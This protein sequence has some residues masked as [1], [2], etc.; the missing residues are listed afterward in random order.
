MM[1]AWSRIITA[2]MVK[3][4]ISFGIICS[5]FPEFVGKLDLGSEEK[6]KLEEV[7]GLDFNVW[8]M[9]VP[10]T[11]KGKIT[12]RTIF[13]GIGFDLMIDLPLRQSYGNV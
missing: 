2:M 7:L 8:V 11:E 3:F 12:S 5:E 1:V 10:F 9:V 6:Q 13:W 4:R